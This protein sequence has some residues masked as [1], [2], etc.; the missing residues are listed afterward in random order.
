[1][2]PLVILCVLV[3]ILLPACQSG[4]GPSSAL[5]VQPAVG[6]GARVFAGPQDGVGAAA[7][8]DLGK[9][10]LRTGKAAEPA[11]VATPPAPGAP[12]ADG[13]C[14]VSQPN[15][16]RVPDAPALDAGRQP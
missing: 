1:M 4:S 15:P 11:P 7:R 13:A 9:Y 3:A 2:R 14:P 5:E 10:G 12:C 6:A 8:V 16:L